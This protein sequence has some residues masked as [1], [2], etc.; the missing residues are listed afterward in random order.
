M[1]IYAML[2]LGDEV[3]AVIFT[4]VILGFCGAVK[5]LIK[6]IRK[7]GKNKDEKTDGEGL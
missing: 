2:P 6:H 4:A 7:T 5:M 1:F 3:A